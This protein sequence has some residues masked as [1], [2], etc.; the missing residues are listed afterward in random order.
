MQQNTQFKFCLQSHEIRGPACLSDD[1]PRIYTL[2]V[3]EFDLDSS[4]EIGQNSLLISLVRSANVP[5][6]SENEVS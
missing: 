1:A 6:C 2:Y 4:L 5:G 3:E